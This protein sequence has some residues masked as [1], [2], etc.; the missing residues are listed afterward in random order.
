MLSNREKREKLVANW[1]TRY[2]SRKVAPKQCGMTIDLNILG[3]K[4]GS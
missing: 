2:I 4:K 1:F 3:G